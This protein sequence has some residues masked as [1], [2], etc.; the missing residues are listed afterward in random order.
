[1]VRVEDGVVT[2]VT[3]TGGQDDLIVLAESLSTDPVE[4]PVVTPA[5]EVAADGR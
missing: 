2:L 4:V 1:L 3:G 5:P